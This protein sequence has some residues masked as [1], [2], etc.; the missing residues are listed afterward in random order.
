MSLTIAAV[1]VRG[2]VPYTSDYVR[3]LASMVRRSTSRAYRFVCFTDRP[4]Q[5]PDDVEPKTIVPFINCAGW[6]NKLFLFNPSNGLSGRVVYLDLDSL[7][8]GSLDPI[9]DFPAPFALLADGGSSFKP[10]DGKVVI[11]RFNSS[12]MAFDAGVHP[13]LFT[14]WSP[15]VAERL[16]GDQDFIAELVPDAATFPVSWCPRLS[17]VSGPPWSV[18]VKIILSKV[19]K[20]HVAAARWPWFREAWA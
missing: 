8:V 13:E 17:Q 1:W 15:D 18:D 4:G 2:H 14:T 6:W 7:I 10:K 16:H 11:K 9:I 3:R 12:V 20:N 5:M 19:P